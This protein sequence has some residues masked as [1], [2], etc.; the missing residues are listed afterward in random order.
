MF[1]VVLTIRIPKTPRNPAIKFDA[2]VMFS[3]RLQGN[4]NH[5]MNTS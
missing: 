3:R 1:A 2:I 4:I 5:G